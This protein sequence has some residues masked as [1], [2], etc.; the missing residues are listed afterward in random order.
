MAVGYDARLPVRLGNPQSRMKSRGH[1]TVH[2]ARSAEE[3]VAVVVV[4][5][6]LEIIKRIHHPMSH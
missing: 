5:A 1:E 6:D 3:E 4:E 2:L